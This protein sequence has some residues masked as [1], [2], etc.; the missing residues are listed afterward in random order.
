MKVNVIKQLEW[1]S[2]LEGAINGTLSDADAQ[3]LNRVLNANSDRLD[4]YIRFVDMHA[5]LYQEPLLAATDAS[6][7]MV[8]YQTL[9]EQYKRQRKTNGFWKVLASVTSA[10]AL[11][12]FS[13]SLWSSLPSES[14][15]GFGRGQYIGIV[16]SLKT[17]GVASDQFVGRGVQTGLFK[18]ESGKAQVRL[19]NGVELS[20]RGPVEF[21]IFGQDHLSL[22][23]GQLTA[24][25]PP[26]AIGF[27]I[28]TPD[29]EVV[30]LGTEFALKVDSSG[31]SRLHVL[32]GEVEARL[33]DGFDFEN[34]PLVIA[35]E[36]LGELR[37]QP[38]YLEL[39]YDP[40]SFAPSPER[41]ELIRGT[42]GMMQSLQEAPLDLRNG[43]FKH[44]YLML[45]PERLNYTLPV[46][47]AVNLVESGT[48]RILNAKAAKAYYAET[49][50]EKQACEKVVEATIV[51]D[52]IPKG[53]VVN[54][55]L[56]HYDASDKPGERHKA[57]GR[58]HFKNR[59]LGVIISGVDLNHSDAI[60]G[61]ADT[62]YESSH[63][64]RTENDLVR[65]SSDQHQ[66]FLNFEVVGFIDQVRIV[67]EADSNELE[68]ARFLDGS[69]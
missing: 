63:G 30:D 61:N 32:E 28:D 11:I 56:V 51:Q 50:P 64:R 69:E 8:D 37:Q 43:R 49:S 3:L 33:K 53:T 20:M 54:S 25:V 18:L 19:D 16:T 42:G 65:I 47:L 31:E 44:D 6:D 52:H 40:A 1:E 24:K 12:A 39:E 26:Q 34:Q 14:N 41:D 57:K 66:V 23:S 36:S 29:M 55:Y 15:R 35:K 17:K 38:S 4:D 58:V 9:E 62:I 22:I 46:D 13:F 5:S 7:T 45:F 10:A 59:I 27:R 21:E 67:V 2:L 48:Y 60:L 68:I